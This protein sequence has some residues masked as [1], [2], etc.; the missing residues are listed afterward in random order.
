MWVDVSKDV[1]VSLPLDCVGC[2]VLVSRIGGETSLSK[3][4]R[5]STAI[6]VTV[7]VT[8]GLGDCIP[9]LC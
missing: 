7:T 9:C 1:S 8:G 2:V 5:Y 3:A 4:I 6:G